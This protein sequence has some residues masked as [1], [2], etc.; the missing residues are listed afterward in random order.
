MVSGHHNTNVIMPVGRPLALLLGMPSGEVLAKFRTPLPVIEVVP[1][2]WR[3]ESEV[4]RVVGERLNEVPRCLADFGEW[5]LHGYLAGCALAEVAP[6][7]E[8]IGRRRLAVLADFFARLA[9]IPEDAL[10]PVP[11]DWPVSGDSQGFLGRLARFSEQ[12]VNRSN[13]PRF[14]SLFDAVGIP[15]DAVNRF[16]DS[17][18]KL[19]SR[20]FALLHTD[21][22]RAN[23]LATPGPDGEG[24]VVIDWELALY[25]DPLHDLATH[26]VRMEYDSKER[27]LMIGMWASAMRRTG[28]ADM[29]VELKRD[30]R[31]YL[32]FEYVQS[33]YPDVMRTAL[34]L[35]DRPARRDV[36]RAAE[37]VC[38]ALHRASG[39]LGLDGLPHEREVR[40]ALLD[41]HA[42]DLVRRMERP[43]GE[44]EVERAEIPAVG[45]VSVSH[46]HA[47]PGEHTGRRGNTAGIGASA[48]REPTGVGS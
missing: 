15:G 5:S 7:G 35:P 41:W 36:V 4:L 13:R 27:G 10:P 48:H 40:E 20:P 21:V 26:L 16:L 22:H 44:G 3:R 34:E 11:T 43:D 8:R 17:A 32:G 18:P 9:D 33:L 38:R 28:H 46:D 25:G 37:R 23:V 47:R 12:R 1:R 24:L 45:Q 31:T 30:L 39:P 29:T 42:K 19:A 14:G 6:A 2:L